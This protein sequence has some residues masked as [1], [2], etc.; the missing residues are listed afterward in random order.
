MCVNRVST[1]KNFTLYVKI[2]QSPLSNLVYGDLLRSCASPKRPQACQ[3][4]DEAPQQCRILDSHGGLSPR[5]CP[6]SINTRSRRWRC[7]RKTPGSA[8]LATCRRNGAMAGEQ[9]FLHARH[10]LERRSNIGRDLDR[11]Y[12]LMTER[13]RGCKRASPESLQSGG[14]PDSHETTNAR[15]TSAYAHSLLSVVDIYGRSA[16]IFGQAWRNSRK[17]RI[18]ERSH[19]QEPLSV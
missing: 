17:R 7:P 2:S 11:L 1:V 8:T 5:T 12:R 18:R 4:V 6:T 3:H 16:R 19:G 15:L 13:M 14:R 9:R 10:L